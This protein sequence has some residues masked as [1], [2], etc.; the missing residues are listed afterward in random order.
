MRPGG[1]KQKGAE[2]ERDVCKK[3]SLWVSHGKREDLFWRSAMSGGRATVGRKKGKDH[4]KH[5]GDISATHPD[6]H[7][8]TDHW[9]V[10]CKSVADL[11][12]DSWLLKEEGDLAKFWRVAIEQAE[13]HKLRPMMIVKQNRG[14]VLLIVPAPNAA[15]SNHLNYAACLAR[16]HKPKADIYLFDA[17]IAKEFKPWKADDPTFL[18]PGEIARIMKSEG[19]S[20]RRERGLLARIAEDR[21]DS[22]QNKTRAKAPSTKPVRIRSK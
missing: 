4:A 1:G 2:F 7:A 22:I 14:E 12:V 17:V 20:K 21:D 19:N 8:L 18:K 13:A 3:L 9:Y 15:G 11:K 10:E 6:G 5:A 16:L